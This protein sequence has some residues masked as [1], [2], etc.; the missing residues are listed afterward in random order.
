[1]RVLHFF[2]LIHKLWN[3]KHAFTNMSHKTCLSWCWFILELQTGKCGGVKK[4]SYVER[5]HLLF[6]NKNGKKCKKLDFLMLG[7]RHYKVQIFQSCTIIIRVQSF[8]FV[9]TATWCNF[10]CIK[11]SIKDDEGVF[12]RYDSVTSVLPIDFLGLDNYNLI[13]LIASQ[14]L[15]NWTFVVFSPNLSLIHISE[16][17]RPY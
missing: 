10:V 4:S 9:Y 8:W 11:I 13:Q 1:M 6:K 14:P 16:P 17:T 15:K 12:L 5:H 3:I 7:L 2:A